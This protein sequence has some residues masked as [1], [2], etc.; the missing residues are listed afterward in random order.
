[1]EED[2]VVVVGNKRAH[3]ELTHTTHDRTHFLDALASLEEAFGTHSLTH[4]L[5]N[6]FSNHLIC[7]FYLV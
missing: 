5:I 1:M 2:E 4:S 3:A 6:G 7:P